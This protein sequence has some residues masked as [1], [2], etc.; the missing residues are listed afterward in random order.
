MTHQ[1]SAVIDRRPRW[2]WVILGLGLFWTVLIRVP[3]IVNAE[4]H[5]DSDLAVDGL[6]LLDAVHG[7]WRWHYPGTPY[8]GITPMLFSYPQARVWGTNATTL[9]SGG[10]V[11]W[12]LVVAST[13]WLAWRG[14]GLEVA[15]W[16][17]VPLGFS[18]LGTI[19]LSGRITGGHLL[20][21]VWHNVAFVGLHACLTRGGWARGATL[22]LWC[23]LGLYLDAMFLFT[24]AGL[25]PAALLA[26]FSSGRSRVGIGLSAVFLIAM[27]VGLLPR[28]IGRR[29]DPHDAYPSQFEATL[30]RRAVQEHVRLLVLHCLPRLIAGTELHDLD[31]KTA[32]NEGVLRGLVLWV[33]GGRTPA[34]IS[35]SNEWLAILMLVGLVVGVARLARESARAVEPARRAISRGVLGSA[36]L[37]V[38]AF[39]VNRN[40]FNSDNYRYL[41][42]LLTPWSL[43]FGLVLDSLSRRRFSGRVAAW[44]VVGILV[45]AISSSTFTWYRETRHYINKQG[46]LV[47]VQVPPWSEL[48]VRGRTIVGPVDKSPRFAIPSDVT[49][50]FGGYWDVYRIA[51]LS[52]KQVVGIPFPTYPNRFPG[53]SRGLGPD[54]GKL[55]VLQ[56]R[57]ESSAGLRPAA[58]K[59]GERI[60]NLRS[61]SRM[62]W[63]PAL[64]TVWKKDGRDPAELDRLRFV[65]P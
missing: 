14:F 64:S 33:A 43:G 45:A 49:H 8:M 22:G 13:F 20:T 47:K 28:E 48:A 37:I 50:V 29:V 63:R 38:A 24:L 18:S 3:L 26:W 35:Q 36:L 27:M 65:V 6:T 23:G 56:P 16:A 11:I 10:A 55:L 19:W 52:G 2:P 7:Q 53:W 46:G 40:I 5:V 42:Y 31:R 12:V 57:E 61:A 54:Q 51:F 41:I 44:V 17:I 15:G 34:G 60:R 39:L 59:A 4:D 25:V 1:S 58:E 21:L 62:D 32:G 9:V 30:E